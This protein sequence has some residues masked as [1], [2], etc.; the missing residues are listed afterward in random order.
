M[1]KPANPTPRESSLPAWLLVPAAIGLLVGG[2]LA[3][4][5]ANR[6]PPPQPRGPDGPMV[7]ATLYDFTPPAPAGRVYSVTNDVEH[8]VRVVKIRVSADGD[9]LVVDAETGRLIEA[10]PPRPATAPMTPTL[11]AP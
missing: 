5:W 10:R 3:V 9:E 6:E 11:L 1:S 4:H 7:G 2:A 8:G